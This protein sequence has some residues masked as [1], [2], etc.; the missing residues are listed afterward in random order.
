M[1]RSEHVRAWPTLLLVA[2]LVLAACGTPTAVPTQAPA[3]EPPAPPTQ[4]PATQPP[5]SPTSAPVVASPEPTIA[6]TEEQKGGRVVILLPEDLETLNQYLTTAFITDQVVDAIVEPLVAPDVNGNYQPLLAERV[7]TLENGDV[8][9]DGKTVT[10]H[11]RKGVLWSDGTPFTAQD[12]ISTY[13]AASSSSSG[14]VRSSSFAKIESVEA[15][16]DHTVVITYKEF[17]SSFLD[18]FMWGILPANAGEPEDM[19]NWDFNRQP[20]GTG[21]FMFKEWVSGDHITFVRNPHY[22]EQGKP[23]LDEVVFQVV[24]SEEVRMQVMRKGDAQVTLWP[25]EA[26]MDLW[27]TI[28]G[29]KPVLYPGPVNMRL[30]LN[31]S[32]P[33]D[34]EPGPTPPHP[35]LGDRRVRQAIALSIDYDAIVNDMAKGRVTRVTSPFA[36]G[37]YRCDIPGEPY[38][39]DKARGLLE[40]A[41]WSDQDGDGIREAHGA[42]YAADGTLLSLSMVGYHNALIEQT[43]QVIAAMLK[44]VGI[45]L[46][47]SNEEMAVLFGSWAD[48]A[49][50]KMGD[51]DIL[52]Y[53]TG[54]GID[55][56]PHI[57]SYFLSTN[58]PTYENN[59]VG[60]NY[61]RWVSPEADQLILEAGRTPSMTERKKLYCQLAQ[62]IYD[63][64]SQIVLYQQ[65]DG[66]VL[67]DTV[68]GH[69]P[70]TWDSLT[71]DVEN[72]Q[73]Q[74]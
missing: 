24:P 49:P 34:G 40:Q 39:P 8:S 33:G 55:P 41:G 35:I 65:P 2:S 36:L 12:V 62:L 23:Y 71:W 10:W 7:P 63:S 46:Q 50:R 37:W 59:G 6:P 74:E 30:F 72:W 47:V 11:L 64:Y 26:L 60:A 61:T 21:P 43:E 69:N 31:L 66:V 56:Q 32:Q 19:L 22:R 38:D 51:F 53:N 52:I 5:A 27:E 1:L 48:R 58:I 67:A 68:T 73:V 4:A 18:Q 54:A 44:D 9:E 13:K 42:Q 14:S 3:T 25:S 20:I 16:D 15:Q 45:Q 57:E 70:N 28:P 17:Y 29:V